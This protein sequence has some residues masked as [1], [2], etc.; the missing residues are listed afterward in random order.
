MDAVFAGKISLL[1]ADFRKAKV[2]VA[3]VCGE[4]GLVV[5]GEERSGSGYIA[6]L[7]ETRTPP[8]VVFRDWVVLRE[9]EGEEFWFHLYHKVNKCCN[10]KKLYK[11]SEIKKFRFDYSLQKKL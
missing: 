2:V 8:L 1:V 10:K 4:M 7:G 6:P 5:A 3:E 9:I 11:E